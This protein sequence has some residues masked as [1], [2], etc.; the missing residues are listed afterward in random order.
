MR[1][2]THA[3]LPEPMQRRTVPLLVSSPTIKQALMPYCLAKDEVCFVGE[4]V[5]IVV[6]DSRYIAEDAAAQVAIDYEVLPVVSDPAK[7]SRAGRA[8]G[9][10]DIA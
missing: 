3:D 1:S 5:A 2:F 10:Q 8:A 9:A 4:P 6:A 7:G